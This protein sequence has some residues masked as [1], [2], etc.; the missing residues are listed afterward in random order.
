[1]AVCI[2]GPVNVPVLIERHRL[3]L[4][5]GP[6]PCEPYH[7]AKGVDSAL[8]QGVVRQAGER[9]RE[10]AVE[11]VTSL[12]EALGDR[13]IVGIG[14]ILGSGRPDFTLRQ[15]LATHAA[16]H[17]A[18]GWLFREALM[19]A[20]E[21]CG[22]P[23]TGALET[24]VY[25]QAGAAAGLPAASL[26]ARVLELGREAGAPWGKDQKLAAAVAWLALRR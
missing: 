17:N 4:T 18:E 9:A 13:Q 26:E 14:V 20:G 25:E 5:D 2:A 8:G 6:L 12:A 15:A 19:R 21:E 7:T 11:W 24:G 3:L 22:L 1:V 23:V 10:M 16:M